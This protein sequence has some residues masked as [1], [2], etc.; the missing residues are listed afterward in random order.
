MHIR[1]LIVL[2]GLVICAAAKAQNA[3]GVIGAQPD[4]PASTLL[5]AVDRR[6][7]ISLDGE[8]HIIVDPYLNGLGSYFKDASYGSS[9]GTGA[10]YDF[11]TSPTLDVYKRQA[12]LLK[13][14]A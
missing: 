2:S 1:T 9:V 6:P 8:W 14:P 5:V 10:E 3:P 12:R 11:A 13:A 7:A 4:A